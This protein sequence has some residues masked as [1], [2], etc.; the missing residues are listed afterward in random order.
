MMSFVN[1]CVNSGERNQNKY[2]KKS[3]SICYFIGEVHLHCIFKLAK[4]PGSYN[5]NNNNNS[6]IYKAPKSDMSL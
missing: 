2:T 4:L 5:N 1:I 3:R 6:C